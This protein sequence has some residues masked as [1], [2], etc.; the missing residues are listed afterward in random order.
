MAGH[1]HHGHSHGGHSHGHSQGHS[2][3]GH[4]H[5]GHDHGPPAEG[6]DRAF[7]IGITLNIAFIVGEVVFGLIAGSVALLADAGHN[8]SDVLGLGAAW[9]AI[10]LGG[11]RRRSAS[12]MG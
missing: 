2:H 10:A 6:H 11:A 3:G 8:L 9:A 5:A 1:S 12:L 4:S 7:A